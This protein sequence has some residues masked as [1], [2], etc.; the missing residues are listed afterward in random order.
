MGIYR[1]KASAAKVSIGAAGGNRV[2]VNLRRGAIVP[3]GVPQDQID[4]LV[5]RGLLE[6]VELPAT[7]EIPDGDPTEE[8]TNKQLD[9]Y[10]AAKEIDLSGAK[11]KAEKVA[12][13]LAATPPAE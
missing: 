10:A 9:A 8:W 12:A 1:V 7:V 11:N 2:A 4:R 13:I 3:T 6:A 5:T